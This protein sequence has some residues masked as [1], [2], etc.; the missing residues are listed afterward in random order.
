MKRWLATVSFALTAAVSACVGAEALDE[1]QAGDGGTDDATPDSFSTNDGKAEDASSTDAGGCSSSCAGCCTAEGTCMDIAAQSPTLCGH[2]GAAC[3][4]CAVGNSNGAAEPIPNCMGGMCQ[5]VRIGG[6][7]G[8]NIVD[9]TSDGESVYWIEGTQVL[10]CSS[11]V[12]SGS[13]VL[14]P[15]GGVAGLANI[16]FS[17]QTAEL[18]FTQNTGAASN[19]IVL[20]ARGRLAPTAVFVTAFATGVPTGLAIDPSQGLAVVAA[21]QGS[22]VTFAHA[23]TLGGANGQFGSPI[24]NATTP[25]SSI[26]WPWSTAVFAS[27]EGNGVVYRFDTTIGAWNRWATNEPGATALATDGEYA[28]WIVSGSSIHRARLA[29]GAPVNVELVAGVGSVAPK[30]LSTDGKYIYWAGQLGSEVAVYY[31]PVAGGAIAELTPVTAPGLVLAKV[32]TWSGQRVVYYSDATGI[33]KVAA[34]P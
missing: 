16:G 17:P 10:Q 4:S 15:D 8:R 32:D 9:M 21:E 12:I 31:A 19:N 14:T 34:P 13:A 3:Q 20:W 7:D 30:N 27:D 33:S 28:Y 11:N 6:S 18:V 1:R 5:G 2:A 22:S 29:N 26:V 23:P 24:Q 25:G